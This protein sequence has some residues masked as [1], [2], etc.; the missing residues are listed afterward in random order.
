MRNRMTYTRE[1]GVDCSRCWNFELKKLDP[2]VRAF[3]RPAKYLGRSKYYRIGAVVIGTM[4]NFITFHNYLR[5][6]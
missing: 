3:T 1:S 5:E 2:K 6:R 4:N